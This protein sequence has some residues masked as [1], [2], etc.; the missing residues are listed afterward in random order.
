MS[1]IVILT[2]TLNHVDRLGL[3]YQSLI[4]QTIKNFRWLIIDDGSDDGTEEKV[5]YFSG[6]ELEYIRKQNSGKSS[7]L[8]FA[9]DR[10]RDDEMIVIVDDDE[11]LDPQAI[12]ILSSYYEHYYDT[13]A[14]AFHFHRRNVSDGK[15]IANYEIKDDLKLDYREFKSNHLNADGYLGYFG[16][17]IKDLRFPVFQGEKYVGPGVMMMMVGNTYD[18]IWAKDVLGTTD[19][20][21]GGITKQGRR[22]RVKSP[23][24]M[25][26]YCCLYQSPKSSFSIRFKYSVMGFAYRYISH[27]NKNELSELNIPVDKLESAAKF[28]GIILGLLW[29]RRYLK[30]S[31]TERF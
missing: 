10:V 2:A 29:E 9:F 6:I 25:L 21:D 30:G 28:P 5:K 12:E 26:V 8:N 14:G 1:K 13:G 3:L 7:S 23:L 17:A 4:N 27:K 20:L 24:G 11:I 18:T 22:L 19:Y 15:I 31:R 16:Y